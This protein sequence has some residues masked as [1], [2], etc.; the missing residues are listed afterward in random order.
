MVLHMQNARVYTAQEFQDTIVIDPSK[1]T[2]NTSLL[3]ASES[4]KVLDQ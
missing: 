2:V 3:T 4:D 1:K